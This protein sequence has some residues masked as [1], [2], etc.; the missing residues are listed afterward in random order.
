MFR[1]F[2]YSFYIILNI[3]VYSGYLIASQSNYFDEGSL[4][5]SINS[6]SG[7]DQTGAVIIE[8]SR[9][10]LEY[11]YNPDLINNAGL[12]PGSIAKIWSTSVILDDTTSTFGKKEEFFCS[13]IFRI[14][15]NISLNTAFKQYNFRHDREG[16]FLY[17]S[18]KSG[19]KKTGLLKALSVSCN[20]YFLSVSS[21]DPEMFYR[22]L[23]RKWCFPELKG[24][25]WMKMLSAI[26]EGPLMALPPA[27]VAIRLAAFWGDTPVMSLHKKGE[28]YNII[29]R[30]EISGI[31]RNM[32]KGALRRALAEGT[33]TELQ[34]LRKDLVL[35]GGKTGT[36]TVP[37]ELYSVSGWNAIFF[38]WKKKHFLLLTICSRGVSRGTALDLSKT[39]LTNIR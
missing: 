11:I 36:G 4:D 10:N 14:P 24:E 30:L 37:G 9:S 5:K 18:L 27:D 33:L 23:T 3:L 7:K 28:K 32:I 13:G 6:V 29:G 15:A 39:I 2:K 17:C 19:H 35:L 31:A 38:S 1:I 21:R 34:V 16:N 12:C 8:T 25:P 22:S 20:N 26:G